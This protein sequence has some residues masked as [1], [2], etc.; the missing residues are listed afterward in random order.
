MP[1]AP[2]DEPSTQEG[3]SH[4][5]SSTSQANALGERGRP[6]SAADAEPGSM[7]RNGRPKA[8]SLIHI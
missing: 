4:W 5:P 6:R 1:S 8:L 7:G 3:P 2:A